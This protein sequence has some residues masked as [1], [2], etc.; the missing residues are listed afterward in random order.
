MQQQPMSVMSFST[1]ASG[2]SSPGPMSLGSNYN[3]NGSGN[4]IMGAAAVAN[5]STLPSLE[6]NLHKILARKIQDS[7]EVMVNKRLNSLCLSRRHLNFPSQVSFRKAKLLTK[8]YYKL[9]RESSTPLVDPAV[10]V[11][12]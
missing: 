4:G 2:I 7:E 12:E 8:A 9:L 1:T 11:N 3:N 10:Q 6:T 5:Q